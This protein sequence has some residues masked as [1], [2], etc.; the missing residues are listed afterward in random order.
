MEHQDAAVEEQEQMVIL[1]S[2]RLEAV[3]EEETAL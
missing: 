2:V 1:E 3:E